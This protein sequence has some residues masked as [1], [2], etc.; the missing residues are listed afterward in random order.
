M[1][2][3][4]SA[5]WSSGSFLLYL[6]GI[7][8]SMAL[9]LLVALLGADKGK[10]AFVGWMLFVFVVAV[11]SHV[12]RTERGIARRSR[13]PRTRPRP[14][15]RSPSSAS[16][17]SWFGWLATTNVTISTAFTSAT[18]CSRCSQCWPAC[19][20]ISVLRFPVARPARRRSQAGSSSRISSRTAE[21]GRTTVT[22]CRRLCAVVRGVCSRARVRFL[23]STRGGRPHRRSRVDVLARERRRMARSLVLVSLGFVARSLRCSNALATP[24]SARS[25]CSSRRRTSR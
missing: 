17:E 2:C 13:A 22:L 8:I 11:A 9:L 5:S 20:A 7:A 19:T 4:R 6:G 18:S 10:G 24:C 12:R 21:T 3:R 15:R 14:S 25:G 16:L 23:G 1:T